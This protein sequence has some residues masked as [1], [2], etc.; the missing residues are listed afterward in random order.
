MEQQ[1]GSAKYLRNPSILKKSKVGELT[2]SEFT[3]PKG[4]QTH[5]AILLFQQAYLL[6]EHISKSRNRGF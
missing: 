4:S 5:S 6:I 1:Y 3:T 2:I